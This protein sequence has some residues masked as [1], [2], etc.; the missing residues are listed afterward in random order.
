ML[1]LEDVIITEI[2]LSKKRTLF[3]AIDKDG[4][5]TKFYNIYWSNDCKKHQD[6]ILHLIVGI[7]ANIYQLFRSSLECGY[8]KADILNHFVDL[9]ES[10]REYILLNIS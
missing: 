5:E 6:I 8:T 1:I 3:K 2:R 4:N 10:Q 7:Q 9:T